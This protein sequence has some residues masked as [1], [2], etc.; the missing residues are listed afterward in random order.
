MKIQV[1]SDLH[2]EMHADG[3]AELIRELDPTGV[4]V[5]V[6]A[7]DITTARYYEDLASVFKPLARK[8]RRILYVP[9][10]HEYYKSSPGQVAR[11]LARLTKEFTGIVIPEND[12][13]VIG[14]QRFIA[15]S[16][17]FRPDPAAEP[18]KRFM[19][20]FSLIQ[21]FEPWVYEQNA[22]FEKVL[23]AHVDA[24]DVVVTHQ[25]PAFDSVPARFARSAMNAFFVCDMASYVRERQPKLW[26]HGH[27]HDRCDYLLGKTRVV[28]NPLGY[29]NEPGSLEAFEAAFQ[30]TV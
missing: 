2:F 21:G 14:G 20:D 11:N 29:P 27:S 28:A 5:L 1:M 18:T 26:I 30:V 23:A 15:G 24:N 13:A 22:A 4:D 16:M 9:G 17:W 6:L 3:G 7:G 12:I 8:Y 19:N 25:L 10:N